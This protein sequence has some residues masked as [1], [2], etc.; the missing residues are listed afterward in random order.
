MSWPSL[1]EHPRLLLFV[2]SLLLAWDDAALT[3]E[4]AA[5][6]R[7]ALDATDALALHERQLLDTLL[8]P[9]R[10]P[11]MEEDLRW[12]TDLRNTEAVHFRDLGRALARAHGA[13]EDEIAPLLPLADRLDEV[14]GTWTVPGI[15][16]FKEAPTTETASMATRSAFPIAALTRELQGDQATVVRRVLEV[17][18]G[19]PFQGPRAMEIHAYRE[20]VLGWCRALA[21]EG[22]GNIGYPVAHGGGGD[23]AAYFTV[24]E[25]LGQYDLSLAIK[26]GV[27]F[28]LWGMSVWSLGTRHHHQRYLH[29]IGTMKAPGCFAMT[30][31]GHGSNVQGIRTTATYDHG[32]ASFIIHTPD[33]DAQK[34]YIG[35]AASH[36]RYATVFA[37]LIVDGTDHGVSAF[38]VPLRDEAGQV[39]PGV[40]IGDCG[41]KM[42]LNG[43][44]NGT[45]RFDQ[46]RIPRTDMLDA[47]A[48]VDDKG[49]FR[50]AIQN[51]DRRFFTMLGTLVGGRIGV[52]R[53]G[54]SAAKAGLAIAIR[55]GDRRR[56]FG[57]AHGAEVP[58]LNYRA[59][60]RRLIPALASTYAYHFALQDM[61]QRFLVHQRAPGDGSEGRR[62]EAQAAGLKAVVTWHV[63]HTLQTC[64]ECCGGKGYLSE[65]RIDALKNDT[66]IFTTFEGDNTV[67][68]QLVA[69]GRL[70]RFREVFGGGSP[71]SLLRFV[72]GK[73]GTGIAEKNPII[74]RTTTSEHLSDPAFHHN[75][76]RYREHQL[77]EGVA[78]RLQ[79]LVKE[80]MDSFDA[81]N[82]AQR[83][84]I[85]MAE[86]YVDRLVLE[87]FQGRVRAVK[88]PEV[89]RV[90][91]KLAELHALHGIEH[92][93]AWYLEC[94]Y[95]E[96]VKTKAIRRQ[97][98]QLCW[99]LRREAVPLVHA[100]GIPDRMIGAAILSDR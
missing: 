5:V 25:V 13:K 17:L 63:T 56:Q 48:Q 34:E 43:V 78:R 99:E 71:A 18:E 53:T 1:P 54:L 93:A 92:H 41:P 9:E 8:D 2:P 20:Q 61:T 88:D 84:L 67:L 74:T 81:M 16:R 36:G 42:G 7:D 64:R 66:D 72:L 91:G 14:L 39:M 73:A 97:V 38:V 100:F 76:L 23:M 24:M 11:P 26:F 45:I 47:F 58:I 59:H 60:Q 90:L 50:S 21:Q 35:N 89:A 95:M 75:A 33:A 77:L 19:A 6:F 96:P 52:P 68:L 85:G 40:T 69:K 94:G 29:D 49:C 46:V 79:R 98:D 86:A 83:H 10:P 70:Q 12:R 28:G 27:Q 31:T 55:H 62:I 44:D 37:K 30:G 15:A 3:E 87:S 65:N 4:E 51:P 80:G 57:P 82:V 32:P 22:L